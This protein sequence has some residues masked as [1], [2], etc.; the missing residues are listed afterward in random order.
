MPPPRERRGSR[1]TG[2]G[3]AARAVKPEEVD[4]LRRESDRLLKLEQNLSERESALQLQHEQ[5]LKWEEKLASQPPPSDELRT[6]N[7][8]VSRL[9]GDNSDLRAQLDVAQMGGG[10]NLVRA[11]ELEKALASALERVRS[12]LAERDADAA[13]L[14]RA[15]EAQKEAAAAAEAHAAELKQAKFRAELWAFKAAEAQVRCD[16]AIAEL[17]PLEEAAATT[18]GGAAER[19]RLV[20]ELW[21]AEAALATER[22]GRAAEAA[23]AAHRVETL[24]AERDAATGAAAASGGGGGSEGGGGGGGASARL[25]EVEAA[26]R[27]A[28]QAGR[29]REALLRE[30][31]ERG[32]RRAHESLSSK[33]SSRPPR[34]RAACRTTRAASSRSC[35]RRWVASSAS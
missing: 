31:T 15:D 19:E 26:A 16:A 8:L 22:E 20:E 33:P 14:A 25:H 3:T 4:A 1:D 7:E 27:A 24:T 10:G 11:N 21:A 29:A 2:L 32:A 9:R 23:V 12:L 17:A 6:L 34:R 18:G 30:A 5:M 28:L 35:D 13:R